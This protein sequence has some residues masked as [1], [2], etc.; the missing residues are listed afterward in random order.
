MPAAIVLCSV[1]VGLEQ[2]TWLRGRY[3][4]LWSA[5]DWAFALFFVGE[6]AL[7]LAA[8]P[9]REFFRVVRRRSVDFDCP[10]LSLHRIQIDH[11]A[12]WNV[13]DLVVVAV[14]STSLLAHV[15]DHPDFLYAA[16]LMRASRVLL[17][18]G[19]T[20]HLRRIEEH[21]VAV[22]PIVFGFILLLSILVYSYAVLGTYTFGRVPGDLGFATIEDAI[23]TM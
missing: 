13:F 8:R 21:V 6:M 20:Q 9:L 3:E 12:F 1:V 22:I 10:R 14:S 2:S 15:L 18:L 23:M 16:R 11:E 19:M 7:R 4:G 5:L 17:L